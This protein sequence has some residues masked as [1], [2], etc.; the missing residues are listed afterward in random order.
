MEPSRRSE[1]EKVVGLCRIQASSRLPVRFGGV[2]PNL[3][4]ES[5]QLSNQFD[6]RF[7]RDLDACTDVDWLASVIALS[8]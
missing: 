6:K 4:I 5:S 8:C 1:T 7:D 2:P 3:A